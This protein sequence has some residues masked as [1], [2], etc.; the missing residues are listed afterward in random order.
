MIGYDDKGFCSSSMIALYPGMG[1]KRLWM[2]DCSVLVDCLV[3][4]LSSGGIV[5]KDVV[6]T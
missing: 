6:V 2:K 1:E 4:A 3:A 5:E